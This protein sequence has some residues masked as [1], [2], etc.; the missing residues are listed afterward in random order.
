MQNQKI[1][2]KQQAKNTKLAKPAE[3]IH[4]HIVSPAVQLIEVHFRLVA[5]PKQISILETRNFGHEKTI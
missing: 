3:H 4:T 5:M 1:N 2:A